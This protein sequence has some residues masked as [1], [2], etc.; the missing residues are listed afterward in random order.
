M[1]ETLRAEVRQIVARYCTD[2]T[3]ASAVLCALRAPDFALHA[4]SRCRAGVLALAAFEAV[5]GVRTG[6]AVQAA[7]GVELLME[8]GFLLDHL[9]DG[10]PDEASELGHGERLAVAITLLGYGLGAASEAAAIADRSSTLGPIRLLYQ[11][12]IAAC[13]GQLLDLTPHRREAPT[14]DEALRIT[15]LKAG[16]L[17]RLAAGVGASMATRDA[18]TVRQLGDLGSNICTHAQLLDDIED[19]FPDDLVRDKR[20]VP[21]VFF[22]GSSH[23]WYPGTLD[24]GPAA[25][26]LGDAPLARLEGAY[27][28]S[29]A[30]IFTRIIAQ[31]YADRAKETLA[32]LGIRVVRGEALDGL[33]GANLVVP[34]LIAVFMG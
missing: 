26:P 11:T 15:E 28:S 8:A 31:T 4:D 27:R 22:C 13:G 9:A 12:F 3:H 2:P 7:A 1:L 18:E 34:G 24:T 23:E 14:T 16:R 30:E 10:E 5:A 33:I 19:A 17:G 29:G 21:V 20:T 25:R 6:P 32:G